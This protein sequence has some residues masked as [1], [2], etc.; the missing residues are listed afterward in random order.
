MFITARSFSSANHF[1]IKK[2][3]FNIASQS[4]N[5]SVLISD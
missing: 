1:Y 2:E 3:N 5:Y 4:V